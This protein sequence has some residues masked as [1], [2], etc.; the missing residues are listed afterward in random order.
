MQKEQKSIAFIDV[1]KK[2]RGKERKGKTNRATGYTNGDRVTKMSQRT[3]LVLLLSMTQ[4]QIYRKIPPKK[5]RNPCTPIERAKIKSEE[6]YF[7]AANQRWNPKKRQ[8]NE[9]EK[10]TKKRMKNA[11]NTC[12]PI[13]RAMHWPQLCGHQ[14]GHLAEDSPG[15]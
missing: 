7:K 1:T 9:R 12:K 3:L 10:Q 5:R 2:L 8:L 15:C 6:K 4:W 11:K 14:R 13:E